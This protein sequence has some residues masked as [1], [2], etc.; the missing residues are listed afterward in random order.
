MAKLK[1]QLKTT[2]E[3]IKDLEREVKHHKENSRYYQRVINSKDDELYDANE[4][5]YQLNQKQKR[6]EELFSK[7]P[8]EILEEIKH[9]D[10]ENRRK[11]SRNNDDLDR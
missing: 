11:R 6:L 2:D 7:I 3:Y 9:R 5:L 1:N 10:Y 8:A 4:A